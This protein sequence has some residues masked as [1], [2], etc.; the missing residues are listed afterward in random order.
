MTG[1][2]PR[3]FPLAILILSVLLQGFLPAVGAA[4]GEEPPPVSV[5]ADRMEYFTEENRVVFKGN[6]LA[7]QKDVTLSADTMKVTLAEGSGRDA[8]AIEQIDAEGNVTFRQFNPETGAERFAT[9]EKGTYSAAAGLVTLTGKPRVWEGQ[10]VIVGEVMKFF[11]EEH[12][13]LVEGGVGL[14]VFP[15]K[16][17][18]EEEER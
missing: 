5:T 1:S 3:R 7:V 8:G 16:E 15:E 2:C 4:A 11:I 10:N 9:G 6:A 18:E 13:F 14:T 12:R 17:E